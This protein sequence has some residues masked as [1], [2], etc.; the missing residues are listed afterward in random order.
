M[1]RVAVLGASAKRWKFGNKAVR[2]HLAAGWEVIPV[3]RHES[4]IEGVPVVRSLAEA[5]QPLDRVTVYLHPE[6]TLALLPEI[7]A[8]AP[9]EVYFNPGSADAEVLAA[10]ER[11]GLRAIDDCSIVALGLSPA[12]FP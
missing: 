7:A 2:A 11:L 12:D 1:K 10:A 9:R 8:V 4:E 6:R 3:N 5:P